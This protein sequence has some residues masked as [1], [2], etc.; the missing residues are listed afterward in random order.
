MIDWRVFPS[1]TALRAFEA[2]ARLQSFSLAARELNV[3]HAAIAQQVRGLED[4]MAASCCIA[5]GAAW[6]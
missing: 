4:H 2:A 1:L 6:R 3:T 5:L